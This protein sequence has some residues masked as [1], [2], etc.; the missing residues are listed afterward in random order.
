MDVSWSEANN[1]DNEDILPITSLAELQ[2]T[3]SFLKHCS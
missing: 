1:G 2:G 3:V